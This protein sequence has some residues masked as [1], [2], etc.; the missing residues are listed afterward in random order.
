MKRQPTKYFFISIYTVLTVTVSALIV[1]FV[2]N[3]STISQAVAK[4]ISIINPILI[5]FALAY[6]ITPIVN[7]F[8]K[9]V[10]AFK[11]E[12]KNTVKIK[13]FLSVF[14]SY[15]LV[16][17]VVVA[18]LYIIIPQ[19][20]DSFQTFAQNIST[21]QETLEKWANSLFDSSS[22]YYPIVQRFIA[23]LD[24][25]VDMVILYVTELVPKAFLFIKDLS[26][27]FVNIILS[28]FVSI[29]MVARKEHLLAQSKKLIC[30][31]FSTKWVQRSSDFLN[32]VD[33]SVGGFIKGK[34]ID[35]A[36]IGVL[37][38][39]VMSIIGL[40]YAM[41]I[42]VIVG[43]TNVIPFF[44]PFIGAIP[45]A[46]ILLMVNPKEVLPFL[47]VILLIQQLDGNFIGPKIL[48]NSMGLSAFWV[49]V[50]IVVM[51]GLF[52]FTGMIIGVPIFSVLYVLVERLVD[53]RLSVKKLPTDIEN[54]YD[55]IPEPTTEETPKKDK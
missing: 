3:F 25:F 29:Y 27:I 8:E 14:C 36:I 15:V 1:Y 22:K 6:L 48:G 16:L 4:F 49:L 18:L 11:K 7:F 32:M 47:I 55:D 9:K 17:A 20:Y 53:K 51:S 42:S 38:Y 39:I 23:F 19:L 10:F 40:D 41:L 28:V 13:R 35:S 46:L 43:I 37:C 34:I 2:F 5:G 12:K 24:E 31:F 52:G 21:Y 44:G 33:D 50:A 54:Y 45:S 26:V 30:A